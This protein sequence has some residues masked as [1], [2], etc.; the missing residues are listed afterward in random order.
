MRIARALGSGDVR[1]CYSYEHPT[2]IELIMY[3][4]INKKN[5]ENS[6]KNSRR[7]NLSL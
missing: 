5:E 6:N 2:V 3:N 7:G 4:I 1:S